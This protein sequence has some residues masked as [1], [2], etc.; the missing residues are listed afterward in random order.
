MLLAYFRLQVAAV[1]RAGGAQKLFAIGRQRRRHRGVGR[2]AG[3]LQQ[4]FFDDAVQRG[5]G[6]KMQSVDVYQWAILILAT[7]LELFGGVAGCFQRRAIIGLEQTL[8]GAQGQGD[9]G[10]GGDFKKR[11]GCPS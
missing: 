4:A 1:A 8:A 11:H 3:H 9:G 2:G 7:R 5:L 10:H 6:R